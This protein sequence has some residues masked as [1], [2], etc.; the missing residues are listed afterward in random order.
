MTQTT[1]LGAKIAAA[2]VGGFVGLCLGT[3]FG[4]AAGALIGNAFGSPGPGPFEVGHTLGM[5]AGLIG[6]A[7][8]GVYLVGLPRGGVVLIVIGLSIAALG[9]LQ[10]LAPS[11]RRPTRSS[12]P[13]PR[14]GSTN[15][16]GTPKRRRKRKSCART[17]TGLRRSSRR[18]SVCF[19]AIC[20]GS[21]TP[22]ASERLSSAHFSG[23][24]RS[25]LDSCSAGSVRYRRD[26]TVIGTGWGTGCAWARWPLPS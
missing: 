24:R 5:A 25:G 7:W 9:T 20:S 4:S 23:C 1:S 14:R 15:E 26:A 13:N 22:S 11:A 2:V 12:M 18:P 3:V 19:T 17:R 10:F 8:L 16:F 21:P 6:G